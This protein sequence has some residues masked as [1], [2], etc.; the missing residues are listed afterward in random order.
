MIRNGA[1]E[2]F[3]H[4]FDG[5]RRRRRARHSR[6]RVLFA[7]DKEQ[8][9]SDSPV[10][11]LLESQSHVGVGHL[12]HGGPD[13]QKRVRVTGHAGRR[14]QEMAVALADRRQLRGVGVR[15][16]GVSTGELLQIFRGQHD[17]LRSYEG[18]RIRRGSL[19]QLD[20]PDVAES[21]GVAV[22]LKLDRA[23]ASVLL[24]R[25]PPQ[26]VSF[27]QD[28]FVVLNHNAVVNDGH[29]RRLEQR[30]VTCKPRAAKRDVITLPLAG[31]SRCVQQ[32]RILPVN[33]GGLAVGVGVGRGTNRGLA[34]RTSP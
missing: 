33:R 11:V 17:R 5:S 31:W 21:H 22:V 18:V 3:A 34:A 8:G 10:L 28:L 7:A 9:P 6:E 4:C 20:Q 12:E 25:D 32:R 2:L 29:P 26:P 13:R 1:D 16:G 24:I 14:E 15:L 30:S 23:A 19:G 27:A